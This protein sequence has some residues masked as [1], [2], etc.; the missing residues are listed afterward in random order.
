MVAQLDKIGHRR[1]DQRDAV[2]FHCL[3][4]S[5]SLM[6]PPR[7]CVLG[8]RAFSPSLLLNNALL[9]T[10]THLVLSIKQPEELSLRRE[11]HDCES[12]SLFLAPN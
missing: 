5:L 8:C 9:L 12:M 7:G 10:H 2:V 1:L 11:V 6:C 4:T 3:D